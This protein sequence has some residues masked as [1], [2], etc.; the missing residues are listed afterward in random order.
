M[1]ALTL[2]LLFAA[3]PAFADVA[4]LPCEGAADGDTCTTEADEAGTCQDGA[5]VA[6]AAEP[7]SCSAVGMGGAGA[8]VACSLALLAIGRRRA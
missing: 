2:A 6:D 7:K 1:R 5:C 3:T 4:P 8:A